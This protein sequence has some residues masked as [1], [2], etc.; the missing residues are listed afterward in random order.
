MRYRLVLPIGLAQLLGE[1]LDCHCDEGDGQ[2]FER[3][4][5]DEGHGCSIFAVRDRWILA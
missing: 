2:G 3:F 4:G 5:E 1:F